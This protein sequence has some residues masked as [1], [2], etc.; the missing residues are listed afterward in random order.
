MQGN[1]SRDTKPELALRSAIHAL[2]LRYRVNTQPLIGVRAT[3]DLVFR[4]VKV[5]VFV[6][7]CFWHGCPSH[8]RQVV[9][10]A[11]YWATKIARNQQRDSRVNNILERAG[12]LAIR[13]WE[14]ESPQEAALRI[15]NIIYERRGQHYNRTSIH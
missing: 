15:A 11:S 2:G 14:H 13:I 3:A 8:G 1:R 6:D 10:H 4:P 7:G 5:A 12:W 9:T